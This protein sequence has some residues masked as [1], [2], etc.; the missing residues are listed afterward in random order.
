MERYNKKE[1][2]REY[3]KE[4]RK[5]Y[6]LK[7]KRIQKKWREKNK[8]YGKIWRTKNRKK[9]RQ[10][11]LKWNRNNQDKINE[12]RNRT[13][14]RERLRIIDKQ[15]YYKHRKEKI[16]K[17]QIRTKEFRKKYPERAK[18]QNQAKYKIK[19][20]KGKKCQICEKRLA[21]V[22]HHEDYSKPLEVILC[23]KICHYQLDLQRQAREN[24]N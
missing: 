9:C 15:N 7:C 22:R 4:Y 14:V 13:K 16:E 5:K 2:N 10:Y 17:K 8:G 21:K 3:S 19:I 12:Y 1:Y 18:A 24:G 23:C 20:P 11:S 6:P